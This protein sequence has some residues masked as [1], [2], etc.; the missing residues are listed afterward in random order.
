MMGE[1]YAQK[2]ARREKGADNFQV[3]STV[4]DRPSVEVGTMYSFCQHTR[5]Y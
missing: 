2:A 4:K 1:P 5:I 3:N